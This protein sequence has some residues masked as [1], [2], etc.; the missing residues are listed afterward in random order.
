MRIGH[1]V[2]CLDMT[3][4]VLKCSTYDSTA[5]RSIGFVPSVAAL[6]EMEI[7]KPVREGPG[8]IKHRYFFR[9][10]LVS[11]IEFDLW[12]NFN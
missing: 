12:N 6:T 9:V 10:C 4:H 1:V 8:E 3:G 5:D 7:C 2:V 11:H